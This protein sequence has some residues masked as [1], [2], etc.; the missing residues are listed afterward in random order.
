MAYPQ[1]RGQ[2][3]LLSKA[4]ISADRSLPDGPVDVKAYIGEISFFEDLEKPYV[5]AQIAMMDDSGT[6]S[7]LKLKG[8]EYITLTIE[9][10]EDDLKALGIQFTL[11]MNIVSII[12]T[13]KTADRTEFFLLDCISPHAYRDAAIKISKSYTGKIEQIAEA[14]LRNHL[15]VDVDTSYSI[16]SIQDPI[17][18]LTPYISPLE[19]VEMLLDRATSETGCPYYAWSTL[20][21]QVEGRDKVR[22]GNIETMLQAP[23]FNEDL[24]Y[25]FNAADTQS[26]ATKGVSEQVTTVKE[27]RIE[28]VENTLQMIDEAAVGSMMQSLDTYTSQRYARHFEVSQLL[29]KLKEKNVIKET[30]DQNVFDTDQVLE[31]SGESKKVDKWDA[32]YI[33]TITSY[34]TYGSVNSY[35]DVFDQSQALNKIRASAIKTLLNKNMIDVTLPGVTFLAALGKGNSGVSVGDII[36]VDF[37]NSDLAALESGEDIYNNERSGYYLVHK[38]RNIFRDTTHNVVISISKLNAREPA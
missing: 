19:T 11:K 33:N 31:F 4:E 17:R 23:A 30:T 24:P 25:T 8:T 7:R 29:D 36:K 1:Q 21:D 6:F 35:H 10:L 3:Y 14:V 28:N 13:G 20:Y 12:K 22:I 38:C 27:V 37:F 2:E 26:K 34:G 32:R 15:D 16:E 5:T 9:A 18:I